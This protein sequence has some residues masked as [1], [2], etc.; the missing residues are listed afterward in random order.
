MVE[1]KI[2]IISVTYECT[3]VFPCYGQHE[4]QLLPNAFEKGGFFAKGIIW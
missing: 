3:K 2:P 4:Q 1:G